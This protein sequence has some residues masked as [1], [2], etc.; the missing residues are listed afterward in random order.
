MVYGS[1]DTVLN[2]FRSSDSYMSKPYALLAV[3]SEIL[4]NRFRYSTYSYQDVQNE[5]SKAAAERKA[6]AYSWVR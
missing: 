6:E 5:S 4:F 3:Y 1:F 2:P